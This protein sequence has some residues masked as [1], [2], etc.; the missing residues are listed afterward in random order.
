[1]RCRRPYP[2]QHPLHAVTGLDDSEIERARAAAVRFRRALETTTGLV[3]VGLQA[4]P[5]GACGDAAVL[6]GQ[7]LQDCGQGTWTYMS[8]DNGRGSHGWAQRDGVIVDIT[9]DQFGADLP[10]V[11]V[12][13][14]RTWHDQFR[15]TPGSGHP[16]NLTGWDGPAMAA[17]RRD[18]GQLRAVADESR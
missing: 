14:D 17:L 11:V 12:T 5:R 10:A 8:G 4:F 3:S 15:R 7:Y 9:A 2:G 13:C 1:M 18:Y 16:A 6:V